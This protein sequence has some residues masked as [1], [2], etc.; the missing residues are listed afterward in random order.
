MKEVFDLF[1]FWDGRDGLVDGLKVG[2]LLRCIGLSPTKALIKKNGGTEKLGGFHV[3][4][5]SVFPGTVSGHTGKLQR[6]SSLALPFSPM[7]FRCVLHLHTSM[8]MCV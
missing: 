6:L 7:P 2:D 4:S 1:D 3:H 8:C 5:Q